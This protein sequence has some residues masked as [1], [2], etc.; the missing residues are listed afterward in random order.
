[1]FFIQQVIARGSIVYAGVN[2]PVE[3]S[4]ESTQKIEI[5]QNMVPAVRIV[6]YYLVGT[7]IVSNSLWIDVVDRC[8]EVRFFLN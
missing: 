8:K 6:A 5:T 4:F 3:N 7:E 1:M 2:K